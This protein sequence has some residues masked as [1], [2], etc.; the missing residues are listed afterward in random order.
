[1]PTIVISYHRSD[2]SANAGSETVRAGREANAGNQR[3]ND[4]KSL[5]IEAQGMP[6]SAFTLHLHNAILCIITNG[7]VLLTAVPYSLPNGRPRKFGTVGFLLVSNIMLLT[8]RI[9]WTGLPHLL[10]MLW[11]DTA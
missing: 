10:R 11:S 4:S 2:S 9:S 1:M 8:A 5:L 7:R 3:N 6:S